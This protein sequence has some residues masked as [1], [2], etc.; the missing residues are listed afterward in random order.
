MHQIIHLIQT[1]RAVKM[2]GQD[3]LHV[4]AKS[5]DAAGRAAGVMAFLKVLE[6]MVS[7]S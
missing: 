4:T 3:K 7:T 5:E 6:K 2:Q 1:N